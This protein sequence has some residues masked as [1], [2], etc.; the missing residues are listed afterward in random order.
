MRK[1]A[2]FV[3]LALSAIAPHTSAELLLGL[4][5]NNS[6]VSFDS[7]NPGQAGPAIPI[8]GLTAGDSVVGIDF[9]PS[10]GPNNNFLYGF[11]V[12]SGVGRLYTVNFNTGAATLAST[13]AADPADTTPPSPSRVSAEASS[14]S[15]SIQR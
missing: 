14:E 13:L 4:T 12:N 1:S 9:R 6:L 10:L 3:S 7:A 2:A 11:A 15:I 8:T 5:D